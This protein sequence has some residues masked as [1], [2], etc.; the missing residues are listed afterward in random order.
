MADQKQKYEIDASS[1]IKAI[2]TLSK[3]IDFYN[4]KIGESSKKQDQLNSSSDGLKAK[5][6]ELKSAASSM[7]TV[8]KHMSAGAS[9]ATSKMKAFRGQVTILERRTKALADSSKGAASAVRSFTRSITAEEN[10]VTSLV[11]QVNVL[12]NAQT[13]LSDLSSRRR[14]KGDTSVDALLGTQ[15]PV[16]AP[17]VSD[18][19]IAGL[20][21]AGAK[22]IAFTER[23]AAFRRQQ[24]AAEALAAAEAAAAQKSAATQKQVHNILVSEKLANYTRLKAAAEK[25]VA[26]ELAAEQSAANAKKRLNAVLVAERL[27]NYRRLAIAA[28]DEEEKELKKQQ[29]AANAKKRLNAV[30]VA[31]RLANFKR[32]EQAAKD[33]EDKELKEAQRAANVKRRINAVFVA[34]KLALYNTLKAADA[35]AKADEIAEEQRAANVKRRIN[36]VFVAEKLAAFKRNKA[37]QQEAEDAENAKKA[38]DGLSVSTIALGTALGNL[39]A[40]GLTL[41]LQAM[42]D[43][44]TEA[45]ELSLRIAEIQTVTLEGAAG[46]R[47]SARATEDWR[48]EL[49]ALGNSFGV[50][51]LEIAE[52]LYQALSN[53]VIEAGNSTFYM[54]ENLKLAITTTDKLSD[55]VAST[56]TVI[57]AFGKNASETGYI[58]SVLFKT[59]EVGRL[60]LAELGSQ[61]GRVSVLSR[62]LGITFEEQAGAIALL[63]RLGLKA[64]SAQTL[65]TNV[66]LKLIKPTERLN[67]LF[68]T[69]GVTSG[70]AAIATFGLQGVLQRLAIEANK[71]GD[72]LAD[73][74]DIFRD[75]RAITGAQGL[76]GNLG[77]LNKTIE[78][79]SNGTEDFRKAFDISLEAV[80][81]KASI[82]IEKLKHLFLVQFGQPLLLT[83][84]RVAEG[85][86]GA[87]VAMNHLLNTGRFGLELWISYRAAT[88]ATATAMRAHTVAVSLA[89][90][91]TKGLNASLVGTQA[92]M[93]AS[94][95]GVSL[96]A[97]GVAHLAISAQMAGAEFDGFLV[98]LRQRTIEKTTEIL[99]KFNDQLGRTARIAEVATT[100]AFQSFNIL[101]A[102]LR[103]LNSELEIDFDKTFKSINKSIIKGLTSGMDAA[104]ARLKEAIANVERLSREIE[105]AKAR[106][107]KDVIGAADAAFAA[108]LPGKTPEEQIAEIKARKA[109][110]DAEAFAAL[111]RGEEEVALAILDRAKALEDDLLKRLTE[112][113]EAA[114]EA[115]TIIRRIGPK[116]ASIE[117]TGPDGKTKTSFP[118]KGGG[119]G[120]TIETKEIIANAEAVKEAE[121]AINAIIIER[122]TVE[123]NIFRMR[124]A[125]IANKEREL[126]LEKEKQ[127]TE[128][129]GFDRLSKII[130]LIDAFDFNQKDAG[131]NFNALLN[132]AKAAATQAG[133]TP[134]E[135]FELFRQGQAQLIVIERK[136]ITDIT[137]EKLDA[138]QLVLNAE[139]DAIDAATKA[140]QA[141]QSAL[142]EQA[143]TFVAAN[144]EAAAII[145]RQVDGGVTSG[146]LAAVGQN[147]SDDQKKRDYENTLQRIENTRNLATEFE[148]LNNKILEDQKAGLDVTATYRQMIGV[149]AELKRSLQALNEAP[150][151][152]RRGFNVGAKRDKNGKLL[153]APDGAGNT[154]P[155]TD[156]LNDSEAKMRKVKEAMQSL[157]DASIQAE[158]A[159]ASVATLVAELNKLPPATKEY[160]EAQLKWNKAQEEGSAGVQNNL[161]GTIEKLKEIEELQARIL[162]LQKAQAAF[163]APPPLPPAGAP[164]FANGTVGTDDKI[165]R[166][167]S[168]ESI[169]TRAATRQYAPLL[170]SMNATANYNSGNV[171]TSNVTFGD[172][173]VQL[174][175]GSTDAQ[176]IELARRMKRLSNRGMI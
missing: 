40:R 106:L 98:S 17:K 122:E 25:A 146:S 107:A 45:R 137:K 76:V 63:T 120:T 75:L 172:V 115:A 143:L 72:S 80:G 41:S 68:K 119:A 159:R 126:E 152:S 44:I 148:R 99:E 53:Q 101:L 11:K 103:K 39:L 132:E 49:V 105:D 168:G 130:P 79:V 94:T 57:N 52:G 64:D 89:S 33:E 156:L 123:A 42:R 51:E 35:K 70:A 136:R 4:K 138:I 65:L 114:K 158:R 30:L 175:S 88:L 29:S 176:A 145:K 170:R 85:F 43:S 93:G 140:K 74:G 34:E 111:A 55:A 118:V 163:T 12:I 153:T 113:R 133:M 109:A 174:A 3:N 84:V 91:A 54:A 77:L 78:E 154:V 139:K 36:A 1:A 142:E 23:L 125:L 164:G 50:G 47:Q 92:L 66:Q 60:R 155:I 19:G 102:Q 144:L 16:G 24:Q 165:A 128:Q 46:F 131:V 160:I 58:S 149:Q 157:G 162:E 8:F 87:D 141:A 28:A 166:I 127:K 104:E 116:G 7:G 38:F 95:F 83:M 56:S 167:G 73:I 27:A 100:R 147:S 112:I 20:K 71:G 121:A 13:R 15:T 90:L 110:L 14:T 161:A 150:A 48:N 32:L 6:G 62:D 134:K 18:A 67:D 31:E 86:G 26:D 96:L 61:F 2:D 82:Q 37:L 173:N 21:L 81:R 22:A 9:D 5:L 135:Q 117:V 108:R 129:A 151:I 10:R 169:M 69:W 97:A 171:R 124:A 59:V